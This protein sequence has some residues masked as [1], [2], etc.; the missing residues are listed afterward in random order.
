[1]EDKRFWLGV[2]LVRGIGEVRLQAWIDHFGD[3]ASAWQGTSDDLRAAGLGSK[4]IE[5]LLEAR[6][7][8]DLDQLWDKTIAQAIKIL[9]WDHE[10]YPP[11]FKEIEQAPPALYVPGELLPEDHFAVAIVGTR[12]ITPYG[13]RSQK[14]HRRFSRQMACPL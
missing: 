14:S 3:A 11:R 6:K 2:T 8:A 12:R 13:A 7:S 10:P 4:V 1:M 5:R 9:T